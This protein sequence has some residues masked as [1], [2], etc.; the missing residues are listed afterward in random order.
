[1]PGSDV[2]PRGLATAS[3]VQMDGVVLGGDVIVIRPNPMSFY[4][5]FLANFI[6]MNREEVLRLVKGST[7]YHIHAKDLSDLEVLLPPV[8]EQKAIAEVLSDIDDE[9]E[10][11]DKRLAKTRDL[12]QGMAQE[13]LTGRTRLV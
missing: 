6:R 11:L 1:M 9:I 3:A 5:P 2:T 7:V 12:K 10:A 4:G 8:N 13:L